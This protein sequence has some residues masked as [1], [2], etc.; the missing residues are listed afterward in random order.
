MDYPVAAEGIPGGRRQGTLG[1]QGAT[2]TFLLLPAV[3]DVAGTS[4]LAAADSRGSTVV[5]EAGCLGTLLGC[6]QVLSE[7]HW[8]DQSWARR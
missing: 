8:L 2:D 7:A 3:A 4:R 1:S 6:N 5:A